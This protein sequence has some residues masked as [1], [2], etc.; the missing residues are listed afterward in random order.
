MLKLLQIVRCGAMAHQESR[1]TRT[2]Q[3]KNQGHAALQSMTTLG[4]T[5]NTP[6]ST[7]ALHLPNTWST[8]LLQLTNG[9]LFLTSSGYGN[10]TFRSDQT[11]TNYD[12]SSSGCLILRYTRDLGTRGTCGQTLL[13]LVRMPWACLGQLAV[14]RNS[15]AHGEFGINHKARRHM[16]LQS[17]VVKR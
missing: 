3:V 4:Y 6:S 10:V 16:E 13:R 2:G 12:R 15:L 17:Q 9:C 5:G 11:V 8:L 14:Y 7:P 1:V